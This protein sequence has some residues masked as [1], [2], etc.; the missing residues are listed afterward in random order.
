MAKSNR[1]SSHSRRS[2]RHARRGV[3]TIIAGALIAGILFTSVYVYFS[4]IMQSQETR[5][6]ADAEIQQLENEKRMENI[7]ALTA[8]NINTHKIDIIVN[9]TG[10]I[11]MQITALF[12][13]DSAF[14]PVT[15]PTG[16]QNVTI[17][18]GRFHVF[19][20]H[21]D[22]DPNTQYKVDVISERGNVVSAPWPPETRNLSQTQVNQVTNIV[23]N[24][25]QGKVGVAITPDIYL[26]I[27]GPFGD[28]NQNG[29]W[30]AVVVNPTATTMKVSRI[31][32]TEYTAQHTSATQMMVRNCANTPVSPTTASEWSCPHD[33]QVQW[34]DLVSPEVIQPNEVKSFLIRVQPG[35]LFTGQEEPAAAVVATVYTDI[36]VFAKAGYTAGM[37]YDGQ[38]LGNVYLTDTTNANLALQE[39]HMF[40]HVNSVSP[41]TN[42]TFSVA[43]ADL[44]TDNETYIKSGSR[45]IINVPPDFKNVTIVSSSSFNQPVMQQRADGYTQIIASTSG[46]TGDSNTGE[47][48]II[49]FTALAPSPTKDTIYI[50]TI[51]NEG[52]TECNPVAVTCPS[53]SAGALAEVAIQVNQVP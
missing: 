31:A 10:T 18:G 43:F 20:T 44:D 19:N 51:L 30:G 42:A 53:F 16:T 4:T 9:N 23:N 39:A 41:G 17:N 14:V 26:I 50:M 37:T 6:K 15:P 2:R 38:P 45:L 33:N 5:G 12:V 21:L 36:G 35:G 7:V 52:L 8:E 49:S 29:L 11:P 40:G 32:I 3:G 13:Y 48:K 24:Q 34:K 46:D 28:S 1:K 47:A 27:P 22:A 25:A